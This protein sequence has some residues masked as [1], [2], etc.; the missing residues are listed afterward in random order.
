VSSVAAGSVL[1]SAVRLGR[2]FA[3]AFALFAIH[4]AA[5]DAGADFAAANQLYEQGKYAEAAAHYRTLV[6]NGNATA[7]AWFNL[8]DAEFKAGALGRAIFAWRKA[9]QLDPR[10]AS[11][12]ANLQFARKKAGDNDGSIPVGLA[13]LRFLTPNEWAALAAGAIALFFIVLAIVE[14]RR[15]P[16]PAGT[17]VM[18]GLLAVAL[19]AGAAG[20]YYDRYER[21]EGLVIVKQAVVRFGPLDDAQVAF[22]LNDGA[23]VEIT[24]STPGWMQV[25]E[26]TG[27]SGWAK[28]ADVAQ[29]TP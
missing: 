17:L 13:L 14:A 29:L 15:A 18:I 6:T 24:D 25:R 3:C 20:S 26:R 10:D 7:N 27:R 2:L 16:K 22:Q 11:L 1:P 21:R 12:R 23:E 4:A 8:G 28:T 5:A 19:S 9:E